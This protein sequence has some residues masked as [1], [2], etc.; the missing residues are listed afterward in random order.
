[1]KE[2]YLAI[3]FGTSN[4]HVTLIDA[5]TTIRIAGAQKKYGWYYP[6]HNVIEL[7]IEEIWAASEW[8]VGEVLRQMPTDVQ[9]LAISFSYFGDSITPVD[10]RGNAL[11]GM[12]PGFCGRSHQEVKTIADAIGADEYARITG[13]TLSTLSTPSKIMWLRNNHPDVFAQT[14]AFYSN[15]QYVMHKLGLGDV[16]DRTMAA[17]KLAINM[18]A[19][20]WSAP[21]LDLSGVTERQM[22]TTIVESA[23]VVGKIDHYGSVRLPGKIPVTIGCHDVSASLLSAGVTVDKPDTIG[24]LMGTYEQ[25][26]YF[27]DE[28]VDGC[29]DFGDSLIFSC[30]YSSPFKNKYTV[31]DAFPTAGALL[32]WFCK[33]ILHDLDVDIG[34]LIA[35]TDLD[36]NGTLYMLPYVENFHGAIVNMS[37]STTTDDIF[38]GILESLAYQFVSCVDYIR[39]TRKEPFTKL[40]FGGGGSRTDKLLQLRADLINAPLG[41]MEN[42]E[43]PT[44]GACMLAGLGN[45]FYASIDDASRHMHNPVHYFYPR[46]EEGDKYRKRLTEYRTL[47]REYLGWHQ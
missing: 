20:C 25:M 29:N 16:Q 12:M 19:D 4:V 36:C 39:S 24:V 13:N 10:E 42:V 14:A 34:K 7:H 27:S 18:K 5:M 15:Q 28:F 40:H 9:I 43:L 31:M 26:G 2:A 32:E 38:Q 47:S 30:C 11:Y 1:M 17:R 3:D 44:L 37:L 35:D 23:T 8:A 21:I 45:G 41:R 6:N 33:N 46:E 22:G